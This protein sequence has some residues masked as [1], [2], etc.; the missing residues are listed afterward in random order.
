MINLQ[1]QIELPTIWGI[2]NVNTLNEGN[3][4]HLLLRYGAINTASPVIVRVH[5]C[6]CFGDVFGGLSCDCRAQLEKAISV[7]TKAG[8]GLIFYLNQEGRGLGLRAKIEAIRVEQEQNL[9]TVEAFSQLHYPLDLRGYT[10]VTQ[11][12]AALNIKSVRL[13]TNN[14]AKTDWL[15][16]D[17]IDVY[18]ESL[19]TTASAHSSAYIKAKIEKMGH[20]WEPTLELQESELLKK[21]E[22]SET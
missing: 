10:V 11:T 16:N 20:L 17:G 9:D 22:I 18:R 14:P 4:S 21:S 1:S 8:S 2:F 6:C 5:S 13:L 12:L 15:I 3:I 19:I 7:I